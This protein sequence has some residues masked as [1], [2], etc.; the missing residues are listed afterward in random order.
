VKL[1]PKRL[2]SWRPALFLL[3]RP[4]KRHKREPQEAEK[5]LSIK[6]FFPRNDTKRYKF[7]FTTE[8]ESLSNKGFSRLLM[9]LKSFYSE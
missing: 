8:G 2:F 7:S 9:T 5:S 1:L 6:R 4:K 3:L